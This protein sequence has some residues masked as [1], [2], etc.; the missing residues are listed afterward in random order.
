MKY[1]MLLFV[2]LFAVLVI[3]AVSQEFDQEDMAA[4]SAE[5]T[6]MQRGQ[7]GR[8]RGRGVRPPSRTERRQ[9]GHRRGRGVRSSA[10]IQ[11]GQLARL[12]KG[13]GLTEEQIAALKAL[14][15][16]HREAVQEKYK[17]FREEISEVQ[18]KQRQDVMDVFTPSQQEKIKD[19]GLSGL[20][21]GRGGGPQGF[22]GGP[23]RR[24]GPRG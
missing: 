16:S 3:P 7:R 17:A 9:R 23:G 8:G 6:E 1:K 10:R 5:E 4:V 12:K 24:R 11:R 15:T 19:L 20:W 18:A 14:Q 22:R 13:L 21:K 2:F